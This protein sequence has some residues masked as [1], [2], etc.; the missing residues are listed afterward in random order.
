VSANDVRSSV[1]QLA[2]ELLDDVELISALSVARM[3][4]LLPS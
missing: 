3:Q 4:E 2:L 1:Q